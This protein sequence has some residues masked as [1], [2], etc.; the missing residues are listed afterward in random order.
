MLPAQGWNLKAIS[1]LF[2]QIYPFNAVYLW[3]EGECL[4]GNKLLWFNPFGLQCAAECCI[5]FFW[6]GVKS[7][8]RDLKQKW[9]YVKIFEMSSTII[10]TSEILKLPVKI[11]RESTGLGLVG[12]K[13][14][15]QTKPMCLNEKPYLH[16]KHTRSCWFNAE[17]FKPEPYCCLIPS[18]SM[19]PFSDLFPTMIRETVH[20]KIPVPWLALNEPSSE[21]SRK[22][23]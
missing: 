2:L 22:A 3:R 20:L 6:V 8:R 21:K 17:H 15:K 19:W 10:L 12:K 9:D 4:T 23:E 18:W 13:I 14:P 7:P 11:V 1:A 16:Y 5:L